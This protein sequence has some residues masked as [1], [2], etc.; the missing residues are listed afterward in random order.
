M[1]RDEIINGLKM[2][3]GLI[4][5]DPS[6]GE[7]IDDCRLNDLDRT[8]LDACRGAIELLK[9]EPCEDCISRE[10]AIKYVDD[11]P[12]IQ[13]H[14]NE[15]LLWKAWI[16]Q[17]PSV[18]TQYAQGYNDAKR[19]IALS[20]EYERAYERGKA[21]A[22]P[23]GKC[24]WCGSPFRIEYYWIDREGNTA[25]FQDKNK[26]IVATGIAKFCP[27]CGADMRGEDDG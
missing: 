9:Q 13:D 25:S 1:T 17:L 2:T 7:N 10:E 12:Y 3:I 24:V 8:T 19:E 4:K 21:D 23:K 26:H 11:V 27:N 6:T 5:F 18:R 16:E 14:P 15:G 22:R 20:G